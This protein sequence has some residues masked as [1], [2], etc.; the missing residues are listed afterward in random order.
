MDGIV[1]YWEEG[2]GKA[3]KAGA[4]EAKP[5]PQRELQD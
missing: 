5:S 4:R 1:E 3:D 2:S